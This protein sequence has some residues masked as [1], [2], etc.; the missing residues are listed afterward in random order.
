MFYFT[1]NSLGFTLMVLGRVKL[2]TSIV[3]LLGG[4]HYN[5]FM[6][7]CIS[8][9]VLSTFLL[10]HLHRMCELSI[11]TH[12]DFFLTTRFF[13]FDLFFHFHNNGNKISFMMVANA[14]KI[15]SVL[16]VTLVVII[17]CLEAGIERNGNDMFRVASSRMDS[18]M[19]ESGTSKWNLLFSSPSFHYTLY[20]VAI[21]FF[22]SKLKFGSSLAR[23]MMSLS[24]VI[25]TD[26]WE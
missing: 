25:I 17:P 6:K 10:V 1:I 9:L 16:L 19:S 22:S 8:P 5:V 15:A 2:V 23:K 24:F 11:G 12:H 26:S 3:S 20:S 18:Q 13:D 21:I 14:T 4:G 7:N